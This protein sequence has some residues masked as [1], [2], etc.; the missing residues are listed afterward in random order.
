MVA[1]PR[2]PVFKKQKQEKPEFETHL[3]YAESPSLKERKRKQE[4]YK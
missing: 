1:M 4:V 2:I 3:G